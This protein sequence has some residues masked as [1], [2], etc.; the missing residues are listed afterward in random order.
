M[1]TYDKVGHLNVGSEE[2]ISIK[3]LALLISKITEFK[4]EIKWDTSKPNGTPRKIMDSSQIM[5]LGWKPKIRLKE[6]LKHTYEV[7]FNASL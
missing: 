3:D 4:G 1:N 7:K 2:E 5:E 6:G